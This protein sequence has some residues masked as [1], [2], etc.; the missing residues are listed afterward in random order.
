MFTGIIEASGEVVNS[1]FSDGILTL[2]IRS[3]LSSELK[4]DQSVAHDGVCLTVVQVNG[5]T[6]T[7]QLVHETLERS[8]F[9]KIKE[10]D[11]LNLERA[12]PAFGRFEGHLV[13]G[14]V[15]GMGQL[16]SVQDG[17]YT[18]SY[19]LA[20]AKL[21]VEKGSI[22]VN[23][24]SLTVAKLHDSTFTVAIIPYTL[25]H[26]NFNRMAPGILVNLEFDIL[27]KHLA[28]IIELRDQE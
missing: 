27:A 10:G 2:L 18:F 16:T 17:M 4:V 23:G 3:A 8:H 24:I 20:Y 14:H 25:A 15:D 13:Q 26:T 22:C 19:P 21:L 11:V 1:E 9:H 7:V 12:M 5:D 28:R 6:H